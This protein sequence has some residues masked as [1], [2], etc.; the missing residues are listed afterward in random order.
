MPENLDHEGVRH[1]TVQA[2]DPADQ[3]IGRLVWPVQIDDAVALRTHGHP[4]H[5]K[6]GTTAVGT[7]HPEPLDVRPGELQL[8]QR[9][10]LT[11][12]VTRA[13]HGLGVLD[14]RP[15]TLVDHERVVVLEGECRRCGG[16]HDDLCKGRRT[17]I[18][19]GQ[20]RTDR[21]HCHHAK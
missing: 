5:G 13:T 17:V 19:R 3:F 10:G 2:T 6:S 15:I 1:I 4:I 8:H 21:D 14:A 11:G 20:H 9:A 12:L 7:A 16:G 18:R